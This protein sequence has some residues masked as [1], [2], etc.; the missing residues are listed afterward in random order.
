MVVVDVVAC[1]VELGLAFD[2]IVDKLEPSWPVKAVNIGPC[3]DG[4]SSE[5]FAGEI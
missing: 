5:G 1:N 4:D 3:C 2:D